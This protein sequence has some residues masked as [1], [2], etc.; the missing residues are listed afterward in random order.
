MPLEDE[1]STL[2]LN[3]NQVETC[4]TNITWET[5]LATDVASE[6][7]LGRALV[8][9]SE[10]HSM[11]KLAGDLPPPIK[12]QIEHLASQHGFSLRQAYSFRRGLLKCIMGMKPFMALNENSQSK[13]ELIAEAFEMC[14]ESHIRKCIP[15][16][17]VVTTEGQRKQRAA[18]AGINHGPTPD[19]TFEPPIRINNRD[20]AWV[21]AKMLYASYMFRRKNFMPETRLQATAD[22]YTNAFGPGAF[23]FGSGFCR[24]LEAEVHALFLDSTPLDMSR[25]NSVVESDRQEEMTLEAMRGALGLPSKAP[26]VAAARAVQ[27]SSPERPPS[28]PLAAATAHTWD[29]SIRMGS[30]GIHTVHYHIC[31]RCGT[32]GIRHKV[33]KKQRA[34]IPHVKNCTNTGPIVLHLDQAQ[35][36]HLSHLC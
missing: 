6:K 19:L 15:S 10:P 9:F 32:Q 13:V 1:I 7:A 36:H 3:D 20:I 26:K 18:A 35:F 22:K 2:S 16:D 24:G 28:A 33:T 21:D 8:R 34:I 30:V 14:T 27:Q 5:S 12:L 23:V 17:V 4:Q 25:I 31:T 29:P 11:R